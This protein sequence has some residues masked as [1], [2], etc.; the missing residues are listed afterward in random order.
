MN[1]MPHRLYHF[2]VPREQCKHLQSAIR[3]VG[4]HDCIMIFAELQN[5]IIAIFEPTQ[6]D[7]NKGIRD[8][9]NFRQKTKCDF[10]LI[11]NFMITES[12]LGITHPLSNKLQK[13]NADVVQ[14]Y[15]Q[16]KVPVRMSEDKMFNSKDEFTEIF[17][18]AQSVITKYG[19]EVKLP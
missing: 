19:I 11:I 4:Q 17:N 3:W 12:L 6:T 16:V 13:V 14:C 7:D 1:E 8:K 9:A 15:N 5:D 18:N 10:K 2:H